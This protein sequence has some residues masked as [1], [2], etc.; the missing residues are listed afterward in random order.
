MLCMLWYML[1]MLC[2][3]WLCSLCML[4]MVWCLAV[5]MVSLLGEWF[6]AV[7]PANL[8]CEAVGTSSV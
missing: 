5:D 4:C 1:C 2:S 8:L 7:V 3:V 6:D